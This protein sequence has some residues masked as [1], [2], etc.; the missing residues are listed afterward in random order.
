MGIITTLTR[1][2][3]TRSF[4]PFLFTSNYDKSLHFT[5]CEELGLYVH[6][7][8]CRQIC[9]F[10]PYCKELYSEE[11]CNE[12]IDRLIREIHLAGG[13]LKEKKQVTSLYIGGGT[14]ALAA[15]RLREI[16]DALSDHFI[17]TQGIGIELHPDN[18]TPETLTALKNAGAT[19]ISIGIQSFSDK[20]LSVPNKHLMILKRI[21]SLHL[22]AAQ[23]ILLSILS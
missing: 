8:F 3:L 16:I 1:A 21:L 17:I 13:L 6:I 12:Y 4:K 10:C 9:K 2:Y 19:K 22:K 5:D 14:P 20:Y 11:K 7:P 18:V 15:N 23:I